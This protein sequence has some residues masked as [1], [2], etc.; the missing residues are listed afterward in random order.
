M[1]ATRDQENVA[2]C[3]R[4]GAL[5]SQQGQTKTPG[6]GFSKTPLKVP[7]NDENTSRLVAAK[8]GE[9]GKRAIA[10]TPMIGT[11][12]RAILGDKTTNAK[13]KGLQSVNF[14]TNTTK[15]GEN[16][17][18][19]LQRTQQQ[20]TAR[21]ARQQA[22]AETR[23]LQIHDE[24]AGQLRDEDVEYCPPNPK[25][26]P[27]ESDVF[28]AGI[29]T[30]DPLKPENCMR[31]YYRYYHS[32][33]QDVEE[34]NV[35]DVSAIEK[36]ISAQIEGMLGELG[37]EEREPQARGAKG[38]DRANPS[39]TTSTV[40]KRLVR[41]PL[42][43]GISRNAAKALSVDD[44]TKTRQRR[45]ASTS[46]AQNSTHKRSASTA[47]PGLRTARPASAQRSAMPQRPAAAIE[48]TSRS[49]IG[50]NRGRATASLL[51][52]EK[53]AS[54]T[55]SSSSV[56]TST[57]RRPLSRPDSAPGHPSRRQLARPDTV[58]S[59]NSDNSDKTITP[60]RYAQEQDS[61][62]AAAESEDQQWKAR[63]H[64]LSL[65]EPGQMSDA[66]DFQLRFDDSDNESFQL[67][68]E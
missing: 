10:A 16:S 36:E 54:R 24:E 26:L 41:K 5:K 66:D 47:I 33:K 29:I 18:T 25:D 6:P 51:A 12:S 2:F 63:V 14:K 44:T 31:G 42:S 48:A 38:Q 34:E 19:R 3:Q 1:F 56:S 21:R 15:P 62:V 40:Q 45:A 67:P 28:P 17:H 43:T 7:L 49:T 53:D 64:F 8:H 52:K 22:Q 46:Q 27:Y 32:K 9:N 60:A 37:K 61:T 20:N 13:A 58:L 59:K 35:C 65:F 39:H 30:F 23:K 4:Q 57:S 68:E 50:F 11:Q 55:G